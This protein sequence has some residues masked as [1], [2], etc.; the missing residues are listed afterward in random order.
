M[1]W[2]EAGS[3]PSGPASSQGAHV[4]VTAGRSGQRRRSAAGWEGATR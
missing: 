4:T 1:L 3:S 2:S